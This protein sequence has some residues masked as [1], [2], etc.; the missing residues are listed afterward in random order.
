MR[1]SVK[2]KW[3]KALRSGEYKQTQGV[4]RDENGYCCLGV[5]C[6]IHR[7]TVKKT[8]CHW[9]NDDYYLGEVGVLPDAVIK[10]AK[11]E[12]DDPAN[13]DFVNR[14]GVTQSLSVLNDEGKSF[15]QI[16]QII[17]KYF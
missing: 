13:G 7:K 14:K 10:W 6:D 8:N 2:E 1:K 5:L 17:E 11:I 9:T 15:K 16:A 4:L 3:L 12:S